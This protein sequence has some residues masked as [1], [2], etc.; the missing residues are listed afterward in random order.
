MGLFSV[1]PICPG[2]HGPYV[3]GS[4]C[5]GPTHMSLDLIVRLLFCYQDISNFQ[6]DFFEKNLT[7]GEQNR[8]W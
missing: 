4:N 6:I 1:E 8:F 5:L 3:L 7:E 2:I